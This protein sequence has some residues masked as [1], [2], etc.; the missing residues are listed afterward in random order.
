MLVTIVQLAAVAAYAL[1]VAVGLLVT[2]RQVETA[3]LRARGAGV[4]QLT[5]VAAAEGLAMVLPAVALA[6]LTATGAVWLLGRVPPVAGSDL[7][8]TPHPSTAALLFAAAAGVACLAVM[9]LPAL[10]SSRTYMGERAASGRPGLRSV[11]QRTGL[12]LVLAGGA[13]LALWQLRRYGAPLTHGVGGRLGVDPLLVLAP[14]LGLVAGALLTLR[15][16]PL[17]ARLVERFL[18]RRRGLA[19]A[20]PAWQLA[21]RPQ[22]LGRA[23]L[24]I[25]LAVA[26]TGFGISYARTWSVSQSDQAAFATGA[27]VRV[28]PAH[29]GD[30]PPAVTLPSAYRAAGAS[31]TMGE[32]E[33]STRVSDRGTSTLLAIDGATADQ[34]VRLRDEGTATSLDGL[35]AARTPLPSVAIPAGARSLS[36]RLR[37]SSAAQGPADPLRVGLVVADGQDLLHHLDLG[38]VPVDAAWHRPRTSLATTVGGEEVVPAGLHLVGLTLR[39]IARPGNVR[40]ASVE[41]ADLAA[42]TDAGTQPVDLPASRTVRVARSVGLAIQPTVADQS[43]G[44]GLALVLGAGAASF[45]RSRPV[46]FL[47]TPDV[48]PD[49]ARL[50]LLATDDFLAA[51]GLHPGDDL[52]LPV[53]G[54]TVDARIAGR[55]DA[56]P[57][58]RPADVRNGAVVADLPTL[59]ATLFAATG[60]TMPAQQWWLASDGAGDLATTLRGAPFASTEVVSRRARAASLRNDPAALG[61]I[62]ALLLGGVAALGLAAVGFAVSTVGSTRERAGDLAV[63]RALGASR[64][65]VRRWLL[66]ESGALLGFGVAV[67][68]LLA[69]GMA[70]AALPAIAVASDG[71]RAYPPPSVVLPVLPFLAGAVVGAALLLAVPV[72]VARRANQ[73]HVAEALRVGEGQ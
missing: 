70:A 73:R 59:S 72:L 21:R 43:S 25:T 7:R 14:A 28:T 47:I 23:A 61:I 56:F 51:T 40:T 45:G 11:V 6:P 46:T 19:G 35:A 30:G 16:L 41:V 22:T 48:A 3:L 63:L 37:A 12:D 17:G 62:G 24:L 50:P 65:L 39:M 1:L 68:S 49:P 8:L 2:T 58:L 10:R 69:A 71:T 13:L 26:I 31:A 4:W 15:L 18:P 33:A 60:D 57:T 36:V 66:V 53:A 55:L 5:G 42:T 32:A 27:D 64:R 52:R 67:G 44:D 38:T 20:V 34:V 9:V 54:I 29:G